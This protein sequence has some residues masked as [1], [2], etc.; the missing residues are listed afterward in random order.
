VTGEQPA[1]D[2]DSVLL[3][4]GWRHFGKGLTANF[5]FSSRVAQEQVNEWGVAMTLR[6]DL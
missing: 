3:T 4:A 1:N 6:I 5:M 2:P